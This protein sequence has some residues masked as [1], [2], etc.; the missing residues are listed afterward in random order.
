M[1]T[2]KRTFTELIKEDDISIVMSE[3]NASYDVAVKALD[4]AR[5][6]VVDA[7]IAIEDSSIYLAALYKIHYR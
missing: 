2:R 3:T 7:I 5:G 1:P 6:D 4:E